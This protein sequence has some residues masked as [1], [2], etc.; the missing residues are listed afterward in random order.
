M[1]V[2]V[3][4]ATGYVGGRLVPRL[5]ECGFEVRCMT[6]DSS[7]LMLDP[8]RDRVEVVQADA[9]EYGTLLEALRGCDVAYYLIHD[10]ERDFAAQDRAAAMNFRSAAEEA[11]L[12]GI[13]YLGE[14]GEDGAPSAHLLSR[15]EVGRI[16]A[17]GRTPVTELRAGLIIGS[18]SMSFE[19]VR[20]LTEVLPVTTRLRWMHTRCQPIAIRNVLEILLDAVGMVGTASHVFEIGGPDIATFEEMMQTYA[21]VAGL[22]RRRVIPIPFF[23]VR[24]SALFVGLV[25]PLP[26]MTA[27]LLIEGLRYERIVVG[28]APPGHDPS[29]SMGYEEAVQRALARVERFDVETHWS[30]ASAEPAQPLPGDPV[31]SGATIKLDCRRATSRASADDV[32][33]AVAR[34][35]GDTGY[36]TM[37]WAWRLRGLFDRVIGGVGLRRGRR[38]PEELRPGEALDFFR[39]A[40]VDAAER[41]LLLRAEMKLPG[42][43]WLEWKVEPADDGSRLTQIA[44][45]VPKGIPGRLYWWA[46]LP[47]HI[48]I[49]RRMVKA[50]ARVAERRGPAGAGS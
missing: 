21:A 40:R 10:A 38:H 49:F 1:K 36:Y 42:V 16:L 13:V 32:F 17:S 18:G 46:M 28:D 29:D 9:L 12:Q 44:R 23:A 6:R 22:R 31:W 14:L 35:G 33:R 11:G 43:A 2:L 8:W 4:G 47:F 5:L 25:T 24:L 7:R 37:N 50:I 3:T 15:H 26:V 48:A 39:V 45:F 27:R 20:H 30:D 19:M 41:Q 34:I